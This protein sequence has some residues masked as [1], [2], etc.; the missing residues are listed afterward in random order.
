MSERDGW[1]MF[2][3][4]FHLFDEERFTITMAKLRER[5]VKP[6]PTT[7][8]ADLKT[9]WTIP[10]AAQQLTDYFASAGAA[11]LR[12]VNRRLRLGK[13]VALPVKADATYELTMRFE[14]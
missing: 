1:Q 3:D 7:T 2:P 6:L 9:N 13:E 11:S 14:P 5:G 10:Q 4:E 12:E 8:T